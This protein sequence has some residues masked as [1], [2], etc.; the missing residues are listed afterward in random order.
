M[1]EQLRQMFSD[2]VLNL[3]A[4]TVGLTPQQV[5]AIL[6][7]L[8][9]QQLDSLADLAGRPEGAQALGAAWEGLQVPAQLDA[10][11]LGSLETQG[12]SLSQRLMPG[13]NLMGLAGE[14]GGN[15]SA[16][17]RL[18]FLSLP[19]LLSAL[20]RSGTSAA[21]FQSLTG[22]RG[23]LSGLSLGTLGAAT[24]VSSV[25]EVKVVE[26]APV[27]AAQPEPVRTETVRTEQ[28]R[29]L[30]AAPPAE[31]SGCNPLWL[32]PLLLLGLGGWWLMNNQ[33]TETAPAQ[34]QTQTQTQTTPAATTPAEGIVVEN[35]QQSANLP[36]EPF[37]MSGTGP[38]G[39]VITITDSA[40]TQ[41][42]QVTV[43][44]DG[45]WSAEMPAPAEGVTGYTLRGTPSG[46]ESSFSVNGAATDAQLDSSVPTSP[47]ATAAAATT[48]TAEVVAVEVLEPASGANVPAETFNIS[49]TGKPGASYA[50]YEDGVNV[51][52]FFA[53]DSG[54]WTVNVTSA[55]PG[56][57]AY[58]I[59]D[60]KG[61]KVAELPLMVSQPVAAADCSANTALAL[62][63]D[64]GESVSAPFRFGGIGDAKSYTV[65]VKRGDREV[66]RKDVPNGTN[67]AWSYLSEPGGKEGEVGAIT[68]EVYE[69]GS[70]T[71]DTAITL[72]VTGSGV[73]WKD[74]Q[75]V[76][77]TN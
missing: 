53:D 55:V 28:E 16:V 31:R 2:S 17:R 67:C 61:V 45:R 49:G 69:T 36:T 12:E 64:D 4:Q 58:I 27:Q 26:G 29:V 24:V 72:N 3:L 66:G 39:D 14:A 37:T 77:P 54:A 75:Y 19:L 47:A 57:H 68:Y 32:I 40:N 56:E 38:A 11:H 43:G 25:P 22:M 73:N 42:N 15:E 7:R 34:T 41:V 23:L 76:G 8:L 60:D 62:S 51:G 6:S 50:L 9:P 1:T 63:L 10:A 5:S 33:K 65:V 21:N 70:D 52:T 48:D 71:L 13:L 20:Q 59:T 30:T 35:P 46:A 74:G 44:E 18:S